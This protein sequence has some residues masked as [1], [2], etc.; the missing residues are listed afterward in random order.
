VSI[1]PSA[2]NPIIFLFSFFWSVSTQQESREKKN[3]C[4]DAL[5]KIQLQ[6]PATTQIMHITCCIGQRMRQIKVLARDSHES[7]HV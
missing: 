1:A 2:Q 3:N 6:W 7:G 4:V 5:I